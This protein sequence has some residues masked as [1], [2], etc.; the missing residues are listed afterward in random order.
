MFVSGPRCI[1]SIKGSERDQNP[2]NHNHSHPSNSRLGCDLPA[3]VLSSALDL[4][5]L[6]EPSEQR[7]GR[8]KRSPLASRGETP[9]S[10]ALR[11]RTDE[12]ELIQVEVEHTALT[13]RTPERRS[14][15]S[16]RGGCS[17]VSPT[18][19]P[20]PLMSDI[21]GCRPRV[22]LSTFQLGRSP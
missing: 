18:C 6:S 19:V 7:N 16:G 8:D 3:P 4:L 1:A 2:N 15:D 20:H 13:T 10:A 5:D 22:S 17:R 14:M 12:T 11:K 9:K 21:I